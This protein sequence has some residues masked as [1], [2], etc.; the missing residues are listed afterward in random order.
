MIKIKSFLMKVF[1]FYGRIVRENQIRKILSTEGGKIKLAKI[2]CEPLIPKKGEKIKD[3][4]CPECDSDEVYGYW[5]GVSRI[6]NHVECDMC[7]WSE[8]GYSFTFKR[9]FAVEPL[10]D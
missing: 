7:G 4:K 5:T 9:M 10:E 1:P 2:L 6:V 3:F 8:G